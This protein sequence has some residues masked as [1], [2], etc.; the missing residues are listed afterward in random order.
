MPN[1]RQAVKKPASN[2]RARRILAAAVSVTVIACVGAAVMLAGRTQEQKLGESRARQTLL[3]AVAQYVVV[4]A[5][6]AGENV[7]L[8]DEWSR[9]LHRAQLVDSSVELWAVGPNGVRLW[10]GEVP[11]EDEAVRRVSA[12]LG[13]IAK[14]EARNSSGSSACVALGDLWEDASNADQVIKSG[15]CPTVE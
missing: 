1:K 7:A 11:A 8:V 5:E 14:I 2:R 13:G 10:M 15:E 6:D 12:Y 3:A 9:A 4:V